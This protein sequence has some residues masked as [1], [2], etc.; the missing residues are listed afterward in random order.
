MRSM[1]DLR[2]RIV[3]FFVV[4]LATV[5]IA[6]TG[7]VVTATPAAATADSCAY[8]GGGNIDVR[9]VSVYVPG[10]KYCFTVYGDGLRVNRTGG[11][12]NTP[13]MTNVTETVRFYDRWNNNYSSFK[14][15]QTTGRQY[16]FQ[17]WRVPINGTAKAGRVCGEL[18]TNGVKIAET[19]NGIW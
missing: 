14:T 19:C 12:Y 7:L 6:A 17:S 2:H 9:G 18:R 16:G 13:W 8:W 4:L 11:A 10:G 1:S 15:Y 5:G 3:R